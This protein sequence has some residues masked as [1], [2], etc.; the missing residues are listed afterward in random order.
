MSQAGLQEDKISAV[1]FKPHKVSK[2]LP[3]SPECKGRTLADVMTLEEDS[4]YESASVHTSPV[5]KWKREPN[6]FLDIADEF[7]LEAV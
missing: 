5:M 4:E 7:C 3:P 6:R 2:S 1:R